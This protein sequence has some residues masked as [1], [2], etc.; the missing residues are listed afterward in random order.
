MLSWE[1]SVKGSA[2]W[3]G[4]CV[5]VEVLPGVDV[6]T[7]WAGDCAAIVALAGVDVSTCWAGD[8][9]AIV[10]LAGIEVSAGGEVADFE[11]VGGILSGT[12]Q[13]VK[14]RK[15]ITNTKEIFDNRFKLFRPLS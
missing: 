11:N 8:C 6:S 13:A 9:A 2:C 4:D 14:T 10:A 3:S 1:I 5:A 12:V 7:C 15:P